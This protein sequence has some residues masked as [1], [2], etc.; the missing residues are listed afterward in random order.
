LYWLPLPVLELSRK[1][2]AEAKEGTLL[3]VCVCVCVWL[4]LV[5]LLVSLLVLPLL[6]SGLK[7]VRV[8][9][10]EVAEEE[11]GGDKGGEDGKKG[12]AS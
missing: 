2:T 12:T 9:G 10:I 11:G 1:E 7:E 8:F 6:L 5:A 4:L 3:C